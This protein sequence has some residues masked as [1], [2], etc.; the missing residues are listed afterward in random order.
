MVR[1]LSTAVRV[2]SLGVLLV[3]CWLAPTSLA[4]QEGPSFDCAKAESGAEKLICEDA[5]LARLDRRVAERYAA[6]K[7]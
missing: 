5:G 4:A 3:A 2:L 1:I 6:A 7:G